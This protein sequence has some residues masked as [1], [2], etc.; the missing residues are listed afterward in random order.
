MSICKSCQGEVKWVKTD[1]WHC[2][3][4]DG[5][6]HWDLCSARKLAHFQLHG[7]EVKNKHG[8]K[9]VVKAG[10]GLITNGGGEK[11]VQWL[12][13]AAQV[14]TGKDYKPDGCDCGLPPWELCKP[15]CVHAIVPIYRRATK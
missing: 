4:A 15:D 7:K 12:Q 9:L 8:R 1:R 2:Y 5:S 6:D 14:I 3:N 11:T 10:M 13:R